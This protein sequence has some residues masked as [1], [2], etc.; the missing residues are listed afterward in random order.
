MNETTIIPIERLEL[1]LAEWQWPYAS[2]HRA[3][4]TSHF[5][6]LKRKNPALW[7]GRVFL[8]LD[9]EVSSAVLRGVFLKL[10]LQIY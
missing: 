2:D 5:T 8:L 10:I 6:A 3:K 1:R 7:N 9:F 4:I